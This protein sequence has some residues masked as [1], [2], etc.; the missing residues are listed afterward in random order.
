MQDIPERRQSRSKA[1]SLSAHQNIASALYAAST[2]SGRS[3]LAKIVK[4][5]FQNSMPI[6]ANL[7]G[8][9]STTMY[10]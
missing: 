8:F 9:Y 1:S 10:F 6:A 3:T 2:L 7:G 5:R 4:P